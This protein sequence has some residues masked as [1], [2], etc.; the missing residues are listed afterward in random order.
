[1]SRSSSCVGNGGAPGSYTEAGPPDSTSALGLRSRIESTEAIAGSSSEKTP[2]SRM[3][4]A[5]S[6]EYWP[7]KSRTSTSS[8]AWAGAIGAPASVVG[9]SNTGGDRRAPVGAH[10]DRLLVLELLALAHQRRCDHH[11]SPLEGAD[12]LVAAG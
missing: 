2:H 12:V 8:E 9:D 7:P 4:R 3:R 6:W 1:M 5:M 10:A 11:L